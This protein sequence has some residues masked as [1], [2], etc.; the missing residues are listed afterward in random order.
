MR[1]DRRGFS[2]IEL[3]ITMAIMAIFAAVTIGALGYLNA[4]KTK[5]ASAKL[6]S[7]LNYIQSE[8]MTKEG[9]SFLYLYKQSDGIYYLVSNKNGS[10]AVSKDGLASVS[11][12]S[13][14][15]SS[16][17]K[18]CDANV[19]VE[20]SAMNG[21]KVNL[22]ELG[23]A[24]AANEVDFYK[25]GYDK[26]TG[27][28]SKKCAVYQAST[29]DASVFYDTIKLSGKQTFTVKLVKRTGKHYIDK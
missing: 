24:S 12:L 3:I 14:I 6:N 4:G 27:A 20:L 9:C 2:L 13:S 8:T 18:V 25:I 23:T 7:R 5:K 29:E 26:A 21:A 10:G 22:K 1:K 15:S 19:D 17:T 11:E 16:G 28:F